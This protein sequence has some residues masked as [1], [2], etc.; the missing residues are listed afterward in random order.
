VLGRISSI[1]G[2]HSRFP[3]I[4]NWKWLVK[5][6][7]L[8]MSDKRV[9]VP[10]GKRF[11]VCN[12]PED[13][14]TLLPKEVSAKKVPRELIRDALNFPINSEKL[15][16]IARKKIGSS[17]DR[18][19]IIINDITRPAPSQI[20]VEEIWSQLNEAGINEDMVDIIIA[21]G[22]HRAATSDEIDK[23]LGADIAERF[24]IVSHSSR[25]KDE[26]VYLGKTPGELPVY[27]NKL[28]AQAKVKILTGMIAPH[29]IAG[30]GGGR[31][32][33]VPGIAGFETIQM[34]HSPPIRPLE[35]VLGI[36]NNNRFHLEAVNGAQ[37]LGPDFIINAIKNHQ[38]DIVY[39]VGGELNQAF[40]KGVSYYRDNF[41]VPI[42]NEFNIAI[43]S[44]GG[45]PRDYDLHQSQKAVS[46]A[47][48]LLQ[49][50]GIIILV[51]R[52]MDRW[53][54]DFHTCLEEAG[55]PK[56]MISSFQQNGLGMNHESK[57]FMFARAQNK[58]LLILVSESFSKEELASKFFKKTATVEEALKQGMDL[59]D[60]ETP[61]VVYVPYAGAILPI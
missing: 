7:D 13:A 26:L 58:H 10:Y 12:I 52:C 60:I 50:P 16:D 47:E 28:A 38:D 34:H 42:S 54:T 44:P 9:K 39:V 3:T 49:P 25:R 30:F 57:A 45:Y 56:E 17:N 6:R 51:A 31:K 1:V 15:V 46:I 35:P 4:M 55:S 40:E 43:V 21:T 33:V 19:A 11:I 36:L 29:H 61:K 8:V 22:D 32:S 48:L 24:N 41:G 18:V 27:V 37:L 5:G 14:V 23:M 59:L 20:F 2:K 53:G